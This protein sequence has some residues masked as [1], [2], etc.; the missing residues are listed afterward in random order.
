MIPLPPTDDDGEPVKYDFRTRIEVIL[1]ASR[2]KAKDDQ[3]MIGLNWRLNKVQTRWGNYREEQRRDRAVLV[4]T[5]ALVDFRS[6]AEKVIVSWAT[7]LKHESAKRILFEDALKKLGRHKFLYTFDSVISSPEFTAILT[8][9]TEPKLRR[10]QRTAAGPIPIAPILPELILLL[11]RLESCLQPVPHV[12][13]VRKVPS[14][15]ARS[16]I[17]SALLE[18]IK[19]SFTPQAIRNETM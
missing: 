9:L 15:K 5:D 17:A 12:K 6:C 3:E 13:N 2:Y 1:G 10:R 11:K 14:H 8:D 7:V 19:I 4:T 18:V 16:E